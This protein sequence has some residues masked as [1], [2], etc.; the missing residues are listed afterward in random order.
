LVNQAPYVINAGLTRT[1]LD[2]KYSF[3]ALYNVVG[4][5]LNVVAGRAFP[6]IWEAPR[7]VIDLQLGIKVLKNKGELKLNA[8]DVLNQRTLFYF[9]VNQN[10]KFDA[11]EQDQTLSRYRTGSTYSFI[12]TYTL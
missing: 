6:A 11:G 12:F 1:F 5:R 3:N 8:N 7:N 10:K 4:R 2:N 9:D